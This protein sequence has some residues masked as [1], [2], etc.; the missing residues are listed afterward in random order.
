[1]VAIRHNG[2]VTKESI[3]ILP[4]DGSFTASW[5]DKPMMLQI[6]TD[7]RPN[8]QKCDSDVQQ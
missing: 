8:V 3:T 2:T 6:C 5:N 4:S 1:M 7:H